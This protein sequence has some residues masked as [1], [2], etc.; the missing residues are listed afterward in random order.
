MEVWNPNSCTPGR[1]PSGP[2]WPFHVQFQ[3][4][5]CKPPS[6]NTFPL[7]FGIYVDASN[8]FAM[9][10]DGVDGVNVC[11]LCFQKHTTTLCGECIVNL[12]NNF[13][14]EIVDT[15]ICGDECVCLAQ[16]MSR[17]CV[18]EVELTALLFCRVLCREVFGVDCGLLGGPLSHRVKLGTKPGYWS[19]SSAPRKHS[20]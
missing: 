8:S 7:I 16:Y 15:H 1:P 9:Q 5:V 2:F 6:G 19:Y 11:A 12:M 13:G 14:G 18:E 10:H 17:T 4:N 3:F 20:P